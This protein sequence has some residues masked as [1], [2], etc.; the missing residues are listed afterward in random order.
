MA[1]WR[2]R[3]DRSIVSR[4]ASERARAV[5]LENGM[6]VSVRPPCDVR[7]K[8]AGTGILGTIGYVAIPTGVSTDVSRGIVRR[9]DKGMM[10]TTFQLVTETI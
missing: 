2:S 5:Y 8:L 10:T 1:S 3:I 4:G 6:H 9:T 7:T